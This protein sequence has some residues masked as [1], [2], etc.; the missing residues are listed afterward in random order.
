MRVVN[1]LPRLMHFGAG[2]AT[3]I[4]L[5]VHDFV[6]H[7][8]YRDETVVLGPRIDEPFEDVNFEPVSGGL[9]KAHWAWLYARS[10]LELRPGIVV[11]HQHLPTAAAIA[12]LLAPIP[13]IFHRHNFVKVRSRLQQ[14]WHGR[15]YSRFPRTIWV[16]GTARQTFTLQ[17]PHLAARAVTVHNGLDLSDWT[18]AGERQPMVFCAGRATPAK[19]ILEAATGVTQALLHRP[20]WRAQFI[21]SSLDGDTAY[22]EAVRQALRPLGARAEVLTDQRHDTVRTAYQTAAIAVVPSRFAEPFGRTAIEAFAGGAALI[23]ST[24]GALDEVTGE[25]ALKLPDVT[26]SSIAEAAGA[27]IDSPALRVE[28]AAKGLTRV[29]ERFE[30]SRMARQLDGVYEQVAGPRATAERAT[31]T[32]QFVNGC[33]AVEP[34]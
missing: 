18:P 15:A 2:R 16:S 26:P 9:S 20:G 5:C 1:V 8:I 17:F 14:W 27:L 4:D 21:L 10:A 28:L 29:R 31:A 34:L 22:L 30:I 6:R 3:A 19:G 12:R 24:A 25:A 13:V 32:P 7:S 33:N 11:V 23:A